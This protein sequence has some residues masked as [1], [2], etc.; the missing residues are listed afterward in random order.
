MEMYIAALSTTMAMQNVQT[1]ASIKMARNV[2]DSQEA[3]SAQLIQS[4]QEAA[5]PMPS[6]G[7]GSLLD[8]RA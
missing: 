8:V 5:P 7:I 3:A 2:M 1:A 4:L 6:S